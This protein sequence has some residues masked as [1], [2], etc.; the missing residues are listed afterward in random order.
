MENE[1]RVYFDP[2]LVS[3]NEVLARR[4]VNRTQL[5]EWFTANRDDPNARQYLYQEFPQHYVWN[6]ATRKWTPRQ[7]T[8]AI[9]RMHFVHPNAGDRF[10]LRLLLT[11]VKGAQS[12]DDLLVVNGVN[13]GSFKAACIARGLLEDDGEWRQCLEE[14]AAM[15]TG[16]RLRNLFGIIL[17]NHNPQDPLGL[18]N[19]FKVS[20][21]DDLQHRLRAMPGYENPT[22]DQIH[23]FGLYLLG[24][25]LR[26]LGTKRL[27]DCHL[28]LPQIQWAVAINMITWI[29]LVVG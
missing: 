15:C 25:V 8:T 21:C 29:I 9:G 17:Q 12:Y 24:E 28:P 11:V 7:R 6:R 14:G 16:A 18:W 5:T 1:N 26:G 3:I 13:R 4:G 22:E 10:Y 2:D 23:D 19:Q 27:S 20:L